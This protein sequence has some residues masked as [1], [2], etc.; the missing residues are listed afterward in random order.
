MLQ[1]CKSAIIIQ[2]SG[3]CYSSTTLRQTLRDV[4]HYLSS[5]LVP[6]RAQGEPGL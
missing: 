5:N 6:D 4:S 2:I 1:K 3:Y